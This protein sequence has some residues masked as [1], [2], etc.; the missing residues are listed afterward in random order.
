MAPRSLLLRR[1]YHGYTGGHGKFRDYVAHVD[2]H[3][4]WAAQLY[5]DAGSRSEAGNPFLDVP[6][7][8]DA[9]EPTQ[10]D[11]LLLGGMDWAAVPA[12]V[13]MRVP[14]INL[15]QHVRHAAKGSPLRKFLRRPAIRLCNSSL[16]AEALRATGEVNGPLR[17]IPSA[18]D[19][20]M[21][22]KLAAT[23]CKH[24]VFVDGVKQPTL[25]RAVAELM[26]ARGLRVHL[27]LTR[28]QLP[29]YL[30]AMAAA[31]ISLPLP[32]PTEGI[33][34]PG[35]N[36]MVQPDCVGSREYARNGENALVPPRSARALAEAVQQLHFDTDLRER[37]AA[38]GQST[39]VHFD[40]AVE[41][42]SVHAVL[43]EL[44]ELWKP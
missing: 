24:D 3:P 43:N 4:R 17:I 10:A 30:Q 8:V 31:K 6:G 39:S 20:G 41:R 26:R 25:G 1:D 40:L 15:V 11:A 23:P 42:Q 32:D 27:L 34:L 12:G 37:L 5:M 36:A 33:Y 44:E 22:A 28:V 29:T 38:A 13:E 14:V 35:L 2:A 7:M 9:W 21:L 19:T 16:V 18:V